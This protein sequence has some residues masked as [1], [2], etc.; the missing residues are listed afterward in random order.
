MVLYKYSED[1]TNSSLPL[2]NNL[3]SMLQ[4]D[5]LMGKLKEGEKDSLA[6]A[7]VEGA[8]D[9]IVPVPE[10]VCGV[11]GALTV[12]RRGRKGRQ[13]GQGRRQS[14][15]Q[16]PLHFRSPPRYA[17]MTSLLCCSS[18]LLPSSTMLPVLRI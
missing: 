12:R 9:G 13:Q 11:C 1:I 17:L 5:I 7:L 2:S 4:R 18:A 15:D 16:Q 3:F 14:K 6:A 8:G 10:Q